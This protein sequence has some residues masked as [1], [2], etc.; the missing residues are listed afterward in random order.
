MLIVTLTIVGFL[1]NGVEWAIFP[2]FAMV[3]G[4]YFALSLLADGSLTILSGGVNT[5]MVDANSAN[6]WEFVSLTVTL[7]PVMAG[8]S[9]IYKGVKSI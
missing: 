2:G 5:V 1:G 4:L 6:S 3:I 8:L 7:L 9:A